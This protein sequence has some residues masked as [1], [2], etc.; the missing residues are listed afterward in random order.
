LSDSRLRLNPDKT[1]I[2]WLGSRHQVDKVIVKDI[3][4][5]Q[6]S[7]TTVDTA[8]DLGVVL[9]SQLTMSAQVRAVCQSTYNYLHLLRPLVRA[10]SVEA[11]KTVVQAFVS[12]RL[13]YCNSLLSGVIDSLVQRLQAVQN[14]AARLVTG[15]IIIIIIIIKGIYIAQIRKGHKCAFAGVSISRQY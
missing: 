1:V 5:L 8:R 15:I 13:D 7:T 11:R 9:D 14:A 6:S 4:I 2:M 10:L 3:L 12:S